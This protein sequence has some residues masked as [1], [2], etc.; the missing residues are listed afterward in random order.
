MKWYLE[1]RETTHKDIS[2]IPAN[3]IM[4]EDPNHK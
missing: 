3:V 1:I 4:A 2:K